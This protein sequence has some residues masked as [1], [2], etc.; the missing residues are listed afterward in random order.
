M[1]YDKEYSESDLRRNSCEK[2]QG[3]WYSKKGLLSYAYVGGD[4]VVHQEM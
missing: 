1:D 3:G 4:G 2:V